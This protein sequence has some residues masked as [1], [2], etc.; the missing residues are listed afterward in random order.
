M[1]TKITNMR[2]SDLY[3]GFLLPHGRTIPQG[4]C[5]VVDGDLRTTL[6]AGVRNRGVQIASL[7]AALAAGDVALDEVLETNTASSS[8]SA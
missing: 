2:S 5:I 3:V 6:A 8:C 7:D 1:K 4:E